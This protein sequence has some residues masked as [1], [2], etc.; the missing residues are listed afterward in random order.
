MD[1]W[2][3][4]KKYVYVIKVIIFSFVLL[5]AITGCA[6]QSTDDSAPGDSTVEESEGT[7]EQKGNIIRVGP[8]GDYTKIDEAYWSAKPGDVIEI[9]A[10]GEYKDYNALLLIEGI[11]D[12][13]FRGVNGRPKFEIQPGTEN[14]TKKKGIW[15]LNADNIRIENIEFT[16]A[17]NPDNK[18]GS[19]IR[20]EPVVSPVI[21]DCYFHHNDNGI[22]A[23]AQPE[24]EILIEGCE[25]GYNGFGDGYSH[26]LYIGEVKKQIFYPSPCL[27]CPG[28][29]III[30]VI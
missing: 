19:G 14:L 18:N 9:D 13:T 24:S 10:A 8:E 16:G 12:V 27:F 6:G 11:N 5:L 15:V 2:E 7:I 22:L 17:S 3:N 29:K 28:I 21:K 25:F 26:N 1:R 30:L 20:V 23:A 4:M